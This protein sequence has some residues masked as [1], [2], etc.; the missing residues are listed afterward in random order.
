M[1]RP[2]YG[3]V[4]V[5]A[6]GLGMAAVLGGIGL[7]LVFARQRLARWPSASK[8]GRLG[9]YAPLG[10]ACFIVVLGIWLTGQAI[11]VGPSF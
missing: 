9:R 11:G 5:V 8:L 10:A 2:A 1:D 4:L 7:V 3:L 6:F